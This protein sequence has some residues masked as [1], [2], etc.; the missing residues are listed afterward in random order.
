MRWPGRPFWGGDI[1]AKCGKEP[2]LGRTF[3]AQRAACVA[4]RQERV[5]CVHG[6]W[7]GGNGRW[8]R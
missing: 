6:G 4:L 7:K 8:E 3:L 5:V 1:H 2:A